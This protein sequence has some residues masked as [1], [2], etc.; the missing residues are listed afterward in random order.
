V[1]RVAKGARISEKN[2]FITRSRFSTGIFLLRNFLQKT[3]PICHPR[4]LQVIMRSGDRVCRITDKGH[5]EE[6]G[7]NK[8]NTGIN[9]KQKAY[10]VQTR[11]SDKPKKARKKILTH[12]RNTENH[13]DFFFCRYG[14]SIC[15]RSG[16]YHIRF[17]EEQKNKMPMKI[18]RHL[19]FI[20]IQ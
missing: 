19:L 5:T 20:S 4:F 7:I 18:H 12:R 2:F 17:C 13:R 16:C 6:Q 1:H 8:V 14:L 3:C 10:S 9:R 11:F 15:H